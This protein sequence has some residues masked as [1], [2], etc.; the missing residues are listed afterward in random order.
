M[1]RV[2]LFSILLLFLCTGLSA[3]NARTVSN[4]D[5]DWKFKRLELPPVEEGFYDKDF[6]DSTWELVQAP[7]DWNIKDKFQPGLSEG[8]AASLPE[9][10]GWYRKTFNIPANRKGKYFEIVFDGIFQCSD[11]YING[12]HL[13]TH[14]YGYS[15]VH[16]DLTPYLNYGGSNLIAVRSSTLGGRPRWYGGGGIY[17]HVKLVCTDP[18]H[19]DTYGTYVTTPEVNDGKAV[20][21][22]VS[23]VRN[24][25]AKDRSVTVRH[26]VI[27]PNG[28]VIVKS[29]ASQ[30]PVAA[31]STVDIS[32]DFILPNPSL[33]TPE[34]PEMYTLRTSVRTGGRTVDVYETPFGVRTIEF[35][36]EKGFLLNGK[37]VKLKGVCLHQDAGGLGVGI[38]DRSYERRLEIL[39]EYGCNAL[40][41]AHNQPS[42][43]LLDMCDRM[44]FLVLDESLDKWRAG[45]YAK[46]FDEWWQADIADMI[47]RDRNH[48][49]VIIWGLGNEVTEAWDRSEKGA[50]TELELKK[51]A[52]ALDPSRPTV[53][54]CQNNHMEHFNGITD[55]SGY[56]YLEA[57][58]ISEHAEHP[59]R[60]MIVT[61]ELPYW[62]GEEGNIRAY[63]PLN[64]WNRVR[65][66][67]FIAGGF[68]W[69]GV[70]Y[71]GEATEPSKGWPNGL[72][73]ICMFEKARAGYHR[74]VWS[75][76]PVVRIAV[77]DDAVDVEY[78]RDLWQ[79]PVLKDDWTFPE[80]Q[81]GRMVEVQTF[82]N[83]EEVEM[84]CGE[85]LMGR[86]RTADFSNNTISWFMPYAP[87]SLKAI[88]YIDGKA[89]AEH[90]LFTTGEVTDFTLEPDRSVLK[91]DGQ[92]LS[93]I[94]VILVD[95]NGNRV[96]ND[97]R[98]V[99][100]SVEGSATLMAVDSGELRVQADSFDRNEVLTQ[101]GR[102]LAVVRTTR[103]SSPATVTVS[104][105]G[106]GTKTV[107]LTKTGF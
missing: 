9:G 22:V 101:Y 71:L 52:N 36:N 29:D 49:S 95:A 11:V 61:E 10:I 66:N 107:E 50:E 59:E 97:E 30:S 96:Q 33:W 93:H 65:D 72:F 75:E 40:R 92:D 102:A 46:I 80:N 48:P 53:V 89:V 103:D 57:R 70:D 98:T 20:V 23:T 1:K 25:S 84:Y 2:P 54:A 51:F 87:G 104:V 31:G 24:A 68:I 91:T 19:I 32:G 58:L 17:R 105:E 3:Q 82:T 34:T 43:E 21:K 83:C 85:K 27:D 13:G 4:F 79:W 5:F 86:H 76:S 38:P 7:H 16:Y 60:K 67:D 6:D 12:V 74:A 62:S 18:V 28:K 99:K 90:M 39:K 63:T 56:N 8:A 14:P 45:Y 69:S 44:G 88:G 73:D 64:P 35:S 78:G 100:V 106:L 37:S 26:E 81:I 15:T 94:A 42:A 55:L 77:R 41:M 47:M